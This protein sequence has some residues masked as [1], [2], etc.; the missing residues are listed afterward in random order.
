MSLVALR[1]RPC[2]VDHDH[3]SP[4]RVDM[5]H[6]A[7]N[8][9]CLESIIK[10][11]PLVSIAPIGPKWDL[12][13]SS[14]PEPTVGNNGFTID[15]PAYQEQI[16]RTVHNH[17]AS[18]GGSNLPVHDLSGPGSRWPFAPYR[19]EPRSFLKDSWIGFAL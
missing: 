4:R 14:C 12:R 6:L 17:E 19:R 11:P 5:N 10:D 9:Q 13:M 18:P 1:L 8:A 7:I 2:A 3:Q 15:E 16:V